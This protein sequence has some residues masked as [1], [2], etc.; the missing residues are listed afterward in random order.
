MQHLWD[1]GARRGGLLL[2][3]QPLSYQPKIKTVWQSGL[4]GKTLNEHERS[5]ETFSELLSKAGSA[6][7][8]LHQTQASFAP[9][10]TT[11]DIISKLETVKTLLS[12]IRPSC[13]ESLHSSIKQ[14]IATTN[15][16]GERPLA[17]LHGDLHFKNFFVTDD[18]MALIDL[19]NLAQGDPLQDLGSFVAAIHY[20]GIFEGRPLQETDQ[21]ASRFIQSYRKH[22]SWD[23]PES[24]LNWH[25]AAALIY[26]RAY[27]C[28]TRMKGG[29]LTIIDDLIDLARRISGRI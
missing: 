16:I 1:S 4:E 28:V 24:A 18:R 14:L 8:A 10:I 9:V 26:E 17:T 15:N 6:V 12:R 27:R 25:I 21:I 20:R 3:P 7:A 13:G 2:I 5:N 11:P 19:D 22:V 29:R 23:V